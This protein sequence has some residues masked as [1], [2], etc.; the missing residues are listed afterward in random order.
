MVIE[1]FYRWR[2]NPGSAAAKRRDELQLLITKAFDDSDGTD[3]YRRVHGPMQRWGCRAAT[4]RSSR[5]RMILRPPIARRST[6]LS[7]T[8][9]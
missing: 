3:G 1:T 5:A 4:R 6:V 7:R 9:Q 8:T 2:S